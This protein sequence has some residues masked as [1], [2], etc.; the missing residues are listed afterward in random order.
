MTTKS[1]ALAAPTNKV[2]KP[3]APQSK[4]FNMICHDMY[5]SFGGAFNSLKVLCRTENERFLLSDELH[6]LRNAMR[7]LLQEAKDTP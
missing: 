4:Q 2:P 6:K 1:K 7:A 5:K 3:E